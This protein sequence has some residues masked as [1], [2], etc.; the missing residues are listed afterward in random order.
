[1]GRPN[2][3][4]RREIG[5]IRNQGQIYR[6]RWVHVRLGQSDMDQTLISVRKK[7]GNAV[8]RNRIRRQIRSLCRHHIPQGHPGQLL[9][10]SVGDGSRGVSFVDLCRDISRAFDVLGLI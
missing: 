4:V 3:R 10:I 9:V 1:M 8:S 2:L 6:G 7:F 5:N